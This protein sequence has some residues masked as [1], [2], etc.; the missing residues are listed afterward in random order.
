[1]G[2]VFSDADLCTIVVELIVSDRLV[3]GYIVNDV[4]TLAAPVSDH[5]LASELQ[6]DHLMELALAVRPLLKFADFLKARGCRHELEDTIDSQCATKLCLEGTCLKSRHDH[7]TLLV[8]VDDRRCVKEP[9]GS[10]DLLKIGLSEGLI[11]YQVEDC[12]LDVVVFVDKLVI[13]VDWLAC[14]SSNLDLDVI[15]SEVDV[16]FDCL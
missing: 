5:T 6:F 4:G 2:E 9:R 3:E 1:M 14:L 8:Q 11:D 7:E 13:Q 16:P 15:A 10:T 12:L